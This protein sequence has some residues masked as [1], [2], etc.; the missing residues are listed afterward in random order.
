[1]TGKIGVG[2]S[3]TFFPKG[4]WYTRGQTPIFV[5]LPAGDPN[6]SQLHGAREPRD[7]SCLRGAVGKSLEE[8]VVKVVVV[9]VAVEGEEVIVP[10]AMAESLK[11][12]SRLAVAVRK[13][14]CACRSFGARTTK[15]WPTARPASLT[16]PSIVPRRSSTRSERH[17]PRP[18]PGTGSRAF[19][20]SPG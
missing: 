14:C 17:H 15:A 10:G 5:P 16:D 1:M 7:D 9:F 13:L 12:P 3:C 18:Q 4:K 8:D 11:T 2:P 20:E 19:A 6:D